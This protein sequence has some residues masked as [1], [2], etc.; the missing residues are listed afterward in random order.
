MPLVFSLKKNIRSSGIA[1]EL[2][3]VVTVTAGVRGGMQPLGRH[4]VH[5]P[6][7]R[8]RRSLQMQMSMASSRIAEKTSPS[9]FFESDAKDEK[10]GF[11]FFGSLGKVSFLG[12][13]FG[14]EP[15]PF[16]LMARVDDGVG[17]GRGTRRPR[18]GGGGSGD[19]AGGGQRGGGGAAAACGLWYL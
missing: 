17:G 15:S 10:S 11:G 4:L 18:I 6:T 1:A 5:P 9:G 19:S 8:R 12:L 7:K 16:A 2:R 13:G 3:A 14:S